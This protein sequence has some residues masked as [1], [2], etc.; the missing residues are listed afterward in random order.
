LHSSNNSKITEFK[1]SELDAGSRLDIFL[2]R[3]FSQMSRSKLQ[4]LIQQGLVQVDGETL[5]ARTILKLGNS[6]IVNIPPQAPAVLK[7]YSIP[8]EIIYEDEW[9]L[10]VNKPPHLSVHPGAGEQNGT[11]VEA[12]LH[13]CHDLSTIG[14]PLR[15]G[16]VHRLDKETSGVLLVAKNDFIHAT[17]SQKFAERE[18]EKTYLAIVRGKMRH[19]QG[20]ID[21][22]IRRHSVHRQKMTSRLPTSGRGVRARGAATQ[23]QVLESYEH[24][25]Y[26]EVKPKTGRTHQIRVHLADAGHPVVGDKLYGG[27]AAMS[28]KIPAEIHTALDKI[29]RHL[30]HASQ[31]RF[32]HPQTHEWMTIKAEL[33]PE[34]A[35]LLVTLREYDSN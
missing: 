25:S 22:P 18:I 14:G 34:L 31:V 19:A 24:F 32:K 1:V 7:P 12:L 30:L 13:H 35:E 26:L 20:L 6:V 29:D 10:A 16:V 27:V 8:L 17:M 33:A 5:P 9:L 28:K 4:K 11:L 2:A 21:T 3:S 23:W 15:P